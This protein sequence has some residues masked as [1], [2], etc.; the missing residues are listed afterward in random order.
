MRLIVNTSIS[1]TR[2]GREFD[3]A[4]F[5][6]M[7]RPHTILSDNGT[8]LTGMEILRRSEKRNVEWR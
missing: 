2:V 4:V 7:A 1:G 3:A 5:K 6:R 8:K